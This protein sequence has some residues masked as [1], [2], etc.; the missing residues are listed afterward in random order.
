MSEREDHQLVAAT[1]AG[2]REAFDELTRRYGPK[3]YSMTLRITGNADDAL[4]ATQATFLKAFD[5]LE[6]FNPAYRFFSWIYRIG[7]NEALNLVNGRR[8]FAELDQR[9]AETA[10][11]PERLYWGREAGAKLREAILSLKPDY[12]AAL[13]LR[14]FEGLSYREMSEVLGIS[15]KTTKSRLFTARSLLRQRLAEEGLAR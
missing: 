1:L 5:K 4:D 11:D 7:M 8:R 10:P 15:V 9:L 6:S 3:I 2:E 12:R 13:V 14:H